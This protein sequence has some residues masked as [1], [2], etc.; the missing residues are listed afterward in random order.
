[1]SRSLPALFKG[2]PV[3][4]I[5]LWSAE[6]LPEPRVVSTR[7]GLRIAGHEHDREGV[8]WLP[9]ALRPGRGR[10]IHG[11]VSGPRQRRAMR[12]LLCQVCGGPPDLN[13]QGYLWLLRDERGS[14][15]GWP[16]G[17]ITTHP[18]VCR[19]CGALSV[20]LCKN[21]VRGTATAVRVRRP[22]VDGVFGKPYAVSKRSMTPLK[23]NTMLLDDPALPWMLGHQLAA[24]LTEVTVVDLPRL[25]PEDLTDEVRSFLQAATAVDVSTL[26]L[27]V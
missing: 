3:P 18:P 4:H 21:F 25:R 15:A 9:S 10:P 23:L 22:I 1:M 27:T 6:R 2:F 5:T 11:S 26:L 17:D 24:S 8:L 16:E 7:A 12:R 13:E 14:Y 20:L 19:L